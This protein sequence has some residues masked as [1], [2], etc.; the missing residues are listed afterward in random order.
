MKEKLKFHGLHIAFFLLITVLY[1]YIYWADVGGTLEP[2]LY[3]NDDGTFHLI[4]AL[5][6]ENITQSPINFK[7]FNHNGNP[8]LLFYPYLTLF[9][10]YWITQLC[11]NLILS[12]YIFWAIITFCSLEITFYVAYKISKKVNLAILTSIV[13]VFCFTRTTSIYHR[14]AVG[15]ALAM[16]FLPL[17]LYGIYQI[18]YTKS[19][20][21]RW[22]ALA[23]GM[24]LIAYTHMLSLV[25]AAV[26]ITFF[27]IM[28]C[29]HRTMTWNRFLALLKSAS[30]SLLMTLGLFGPMLQFQTFTKIKEPLLYQLSDT[31]MSVNQVVDASL[32]NN[33]ASEDNLGIVL[34]IFLIVSVIGFSKFKST[35]FK[36]LVISGL[37][38][39]FLST[40]LFPWHFFQDIFYNIQFPWRF[41]VLASIA[42][43][44]TGSY[45]IIQ[46][47]Q[48]PKMQNLAVSCLI[49]VLVLINWGTISRVQTQDSFFSEQ[50]F[51]NEM[52]STS[53]N[54]INDYTPIV[55]EEQGIDISFDRQN[56]QEHKI[57]VSDDKWVYPTKL[58]Y[59][60]NKLTLTLDM[61]EKEQNTVILPVWAY[62]GEQV[63]LNGQSIKVKK[64]YNGATQVPVKNGKNVYTITYKYTLLAR[65]MQIISLISMLAFIG[66][67]IF[68]LYRPKQAS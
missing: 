62:P 45:I 2:V 29:I 46:L 52:N 16:T 61:P 24:T 5:S 28:S 39:S 41:F 18:F 37:I 47:C 17:V 51:I 43:S 13:Y 12:Y 56:I 6:L 55:G 36:D 10:L 34:L 50:S 60:A 27:L 59:T 57:K 38:F 65:T 1:S 9:P 44:F 63:T 4:R 68:D 33:L 7:F 14:L 20:K 42:I 15:E 40:N 26:F 21:P 3:H 8:T 67:W 11:N 58:K 31:A 25:M 35:F 54:G 64:A 22:F 48:T 19:T 66:L 30:F 23:L 32:S 49:V 53:F